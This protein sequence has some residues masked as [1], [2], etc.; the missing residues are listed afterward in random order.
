[1]IGIAGA[2]EKCEWLLNELKFD[3]ALNYKS[4]SFKEELAA[5]TP[6]FVDVYWDNVGGA[7]LD[8]MLERAAKNARFVLCGAN[9]E[10]NPERKQTVGVQNLAHAIAQRITLKGM[11]ILDHKAN[12]PRAREEM[13]R[14]IEEGK[15]KSRV[16]MV[17]GGL[18]EVEAGHAMMYRGDH[19]G[20]AL[21]EVKPLSEES[22]AELA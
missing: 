9:S 19:I 18:K 10:Y 13:S 2:D 16:A 6:D 5:A 15:I 21:L 22:S 8:A 14:W 20:K 3:A 12:F 17:R 7:L 4:P 1:M 11:L